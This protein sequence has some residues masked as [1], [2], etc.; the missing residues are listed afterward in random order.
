MANK[1]LSDYIMKQSGSTNP[2]DVMG[3]KLA[4]PTWVKPEQGFSSIQDEIAALQARAGALN[5]SGNVPVG[6][7]ITQKQAEIQPQLQPQAQ[8][9][10]QP[11]QQQ[12]QPQPQAQPQIEPTPTPTQ[13]VSSF[14]AQPEEKEDPRYTALQAIVDEY[15]AT[16]S[17]LEQFQKL[18]EQY[19]IPDLNENITDIMNKAMSVE[20]QLEDLPADVQKRVR[21]VFRT[22]KAVEKLTTA[23]AKPLT[24]LY[25]SM[26]RALGASQTERALRMQEIETMMGLVDK[27]TKRKME[28]LELGFKL[29][30]LEVGIE[31]EGTM[32]AKE[33]ADLARTE[34]LTEKTRAE[35]EALGQPEAPEILSPTEAATLGVPYGTTE[36]QAAA[37][38]ITP[39]RWKETVAGEEAKPL[40]LTKF[41]IETGLVGHTEQQATDILTSD[42]A[43]DW[44]I[45]QETPNGAKRP[46][47]SLIQ[48]KWLNFVAPIRE[49]ASG[50]L[51]E[52][53]KWEKES[54]V[55]QWL[56]SD[57]ARAMSDEQI[58]SEIRKFGLSPATFGF[59]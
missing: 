20:K 58:A 43:P 23:E 33:A 16:P 4:N 40:G 34:A 7:L 3:K 44:F 24:S 18:S 53:S 17:T 27:D 26:S 46:P 22:R 42:V 13:E 52:E 39:A 37:M 19:G 21:D 55:W 50:G 56:E 2:F 57:E 28:A 5:V 54:T 15:K 59:N 9:Q 49:K 12:P 6:E 36:A 32:T 10:A 45:K 25:N 30:E 38:G 29:A 1:S 48:S 11:T 51:V 41:N 8:P 31:A 47:Y 35:T 14:S